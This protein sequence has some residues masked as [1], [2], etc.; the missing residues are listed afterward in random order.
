MVEV[1]GQNGIA[2]SMYKRNLRGD[3]A[4]QDQF[5]WEV[6]QKREYMAEN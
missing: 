2:G 3:A 1:T 5:I 4:L 6:R